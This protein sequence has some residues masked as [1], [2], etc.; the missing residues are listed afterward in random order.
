LK[1]RSIINYPKVLKGLIVAV[2]D[3]K[4][5]VLKAR[6]SLKQIGP[7]IKRSLQRNTTVRF[8]TSIKHRQPCQMLPV[9]LNH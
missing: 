1:F 2:W 6:W 9:F 4:E 7:S 3:R 5:V 8:L